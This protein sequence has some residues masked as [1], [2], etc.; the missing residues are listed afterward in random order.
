MLNGP[1]NQIKE[2]QDKKLPLQQFSK[3]LSDSEDYVQKR[4]EAHL[5]RNQFARSQSQ[6]HSYSHMQSQPSASV[7]EE[8]ETSEGEKPKGILKKSQAYVPRVHERITNYQYNVEQ[9]QSKYQSTLPWNSK[10]CRENSQDSMIR[11]TASS[12]C[13]FVKNKTPIRMSGNFTNMNKLRNDETHTNGLE[14]ISIYQK[15]KETISDPTKLSAK[16]PGHF[17]NDFFPPASSEND[18]GPSQS[19]LMETT[20]MASVCENNNI[21]VIS[22][23]QVP[24]VI[25]NSISSNSSQHNCRTLFQPSQCSNKNSNILS[26]NDQRTFSSSITISLSSEKKTEKDQL[27][28]INSRNITSSASNNNAP[29]S[30][31]SSSCTD[32]RYSSCEP[33]AKNF[34]NSNSVT[35]DDRGKNKDE[36][37][38]NTGETGEEISEKLGVNQMIC[39][40]NSSEEEEIQKELST[41]LTNTNGHKDVNTGSALHQPRFLQNPMKYNP[42]NFSKTSS[43]LNSFEYLDVRNSDSEKQ[44]CPN[45]TQKVSEHQ[46]FPISVLDNTIS[47]FSLPKPGS[48][49][50][51]LSINVPPSENGKY[52][53]SLTHPAAAT[54]LPPTS[55]VS[56][57]TQVAQ[58]SVTN[59]KSEYEN[60][61]I[62]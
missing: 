48:L 36:G 11:K 14:N 10:I 30:S 23:T 15:D 3:N 45:D 47:N 53:L 24:E 39:N 40:S 42:K 26:T 9:T 34:L 27:R 57:S 54:T 1:I 2:F 25:N 5:D 33:K 31:A 20:R 41:I 32:S 16:K 51:D 29:F 13:L 38:T 61:F 62:G 43:N 55:D 12:P 58:D 6:S 21:P 44:I 56:I 7:S 52:G 49:K 37:R 8:R 22:Q 50:S 46:D 19:M 60:M 35:T 59:A 18:T 4:R 17:Y 28:S